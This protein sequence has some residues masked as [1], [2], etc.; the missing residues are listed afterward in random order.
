[1]LKCYT[2]NYGICRT[3][4]VVTLSSD[5]IQSIANTQEL[6][7]DFSFECALSCGKLLTGTE[8]EK[9]HARRIAIHI[10][11]RWS[12]VPKAT[13]PIWADII[14]AVGF[15]P[16]LHKISETDAI[17]SLGEVI[18]LKNSLSEYL[19]ETYMHTAQ[20]DLLKY[21][22]SD[23]NVVA[24]AP[25][26]FGKSL[27]IEELVAS[28]F[29]RNIIIIQP[30]LA[31]L[32]ETRIKLKKYKQNYKIILRTSQEAVNDK[33][34]LFL[35]TAERVME[36]A[37]LPEIHL[38]I[39]DEFYKMSLKR[40]DDRADV[41]N[42]AFLKVYDTFTPK[43]YLLGPNIDS[44]TEGFANKY[45]AVFYKSEYSLV[46]TA[47]IS[48]PTDETEKDRKSKLFDLLDKQQDQQTLI[49]CSSPSRARG[50]ARA[51]QKHL[52]DMNALKT[53]NLP[54]IE[55]LKSYYPNWSL[56]EQLSYGIAIHD[57][58]LPKHL[59][60]SIIKNFNDEHIRCV[61]C[62][63]T[64]I[65]GVNT[66]AKNVVIFDS[67]KGSKEID[68][69]DF[70][71]IKG[72]SGRLMEHYLGNV[73]CF[74]P[75]PKET[76]VVIDIP[77]WEQDANILTSE[78]LVNIKATDI[79]P[80]VK[81]R[82]DQLN[83]FDSELLK[84]LKQN[85]TNISGQM[86]IY[87]RL[88]SEISSNLNYI[89]WSQMPS[90]EQMLYVLAL[91]D[92]NTFSF[93]E[94]KYIRS[95]KQL[96]FLLSKY[97]ESGSLTAIIKDIYDYSINQLKNQ[98][99]QKKAEHYDKAIENAFHIYRHWF[100]FTVP[101]AFRVVDSLQRYVCQKHRIKAGSYSYFVQQLEND[102]IRNNL[103]I[104]V[105]Y[106]IPSETVRKI[107]KLIPEYLEEE[108][109]IQ[110]IQENKDAIFASLMRYEQERIEQCL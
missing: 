27:L 33:G 3:C 17:D 78:I 34:N 83:S 101:K 30:T 95:V 87:R 106:G 92:K 64:I 21:L 71:N 74:V 84:I 55:W 104:L 29:Y 16:Y 7:Y 100:Q 90:Y 5:I 10:L 58:S 4:E 60:A 79:K 37:N 42:N 56:I 12:D 94:S 11:D 51:Y 24:S 82:F 32:D 76:A 57:G 13:K 2:K 23:K 96:A 25:T 61:F 9:S 105:E 72:R 69:F 44:I 91:C 63:S 45:N 102:F 39:I 49:Y 59:G 40:V 48:V 46:D 110:H 86:D 50:L 108:A 70:N 103:S 14:E 26:S 98:T 43:F 81:D 99:D 66:S 41:L 89:S 19:P 47:V 97:R 22:Q 53:D 52:M 28:K 31:L 20:K 15:Y 62:T 68:F 8:D 80:Q 6:T 107:A 77:F 73:F 36:Y 1:L 67:K 109:V 75:I 85:G 88:N 54:I 65:E 93:D 38:L 18:R 35:L